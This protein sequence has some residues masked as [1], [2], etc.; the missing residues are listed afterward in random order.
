MTELMF[1]EYDVLTNTPE[2]SD[3][4]PCLLKREIELESFMRNQGL[5]RS[6]NNDTRA[7]QNKRSSDTSFGSALLR[8]NLKTVSDALD[9]KLSKIR[10]GEAG[11]RRSSLRLIKDMES[12]VIA[13]IAL[14]HVIN[15]FSKTGVSFTLNNI[16]KIVGKALEDEAMAVKF[17]TYAKK[18]YDMA[19][20]K[21]KDRFEAGRTVAK[22][23]RTLSKFMNKV[24]QGYF[25]M[26]PNADV[27]WESWSASDAANVGIQVVTI[28]A[29]SSGLIQINKRVTDTGKYMYHVSLTDGLIQ[30][31]K[32]YASKSGLMSPVCLPTVIPPKPYT[33]PFDG[34]YHSSLI[35]RYNLIKTN[36]RKY[37][38]SL[39]TEKVIAQMKPVYN[40][41]N[42]AASTAWRINTQVL[43]VMADLWRRNVN[44]D[45]LPMQEDIPLPVCPKCGRPIRQEDKRHECFDD[46]A[47]YRLWANEAKEVYARNQAEKSKALIV[48]RLLWIAEMYRNDKAIY[49][50]YQL[51]FRGRIYALPQFLNPQGSD[52]SKGLLTFAEGKP[53]GT[54]EAAD[55]LAIHVANTYGKDKLSFRDRIQWTKDNTEMI[56]SVASAPLDTL[57]L[58]TGTDSP[59]CFL[60]A[61][62]E[63][64]GYMNDGLSY[65]SH[66]PVAQ[67][68]TCSG[69]QHYSAMLRDRTGGE[70]VNLTPADKP[71]DIYG[72]VASQVK[73]HL[74]AITVSDFEE[75]EM[76]QQWLNSG[77][78]NRKLTK[79]AVMTLPYGVTFQSAK[80]YIVERMTEARD[81]EHM[82]L[83]WASHI[84]TIEEFNA[85]VEKEGMAAALKANNPL[86][87]AGSWIAKHVWTAISEVIESAPTAM[88]WLKTMARAV[89]DAGKPVVW[90]A[91]SG[92]IVQQKYTQQKER[93][94]KTS[95]AGNVIFRTGTDGRNL[96]TETAED[97]RVEFTILE[98]TDEIDK[99][100]QASGVA[101]NFVHSMDAS[102]LVFAVNMSRDKYGISSFALIHDSFGTHAADSANLAKATRDSFIDMYETHDVIAEFEAQVRSVVSADRELPE[103]PQRGELDLNAV[104]ESLYFFS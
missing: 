49:F 15:H 7:M 33:T 103:S 91:P 18:Q 88:A 84:T 75:Y 27:A 71:S 82:S 43:D 6:E 90:T 55:W 87:M 67:D 34:G 24:S 60:A 63:W 53:L 50:P 52:L 47:V 69:L 72:I 2:Y 61:C 93:T 68:G 36:D 74:E 14:K 23:Y 4:N 79:R 30:W 102:A 99:L 85:M 59:F 20:K 64:Q 45:C 94:V 44:V 8:K 101:P 98:D 5:I 95:L 42:T 25:G 40:A 26:S 54:Q 96:S 46:P 38:K 100:K 70:A 41:V 48:H 73:A 31:I 39:N 57:H 78:L 29:E 89:V 76:A 65:V 17:A 86:G 83:P 32:D 66:I 1:N 13:Y 62:F 104:R 92:L 21:I 35:R 56:L 97:V 22:D 81:K 28:V 12:E 37:L 77:L 80:N 16:G 10:A 51:D 9:V 3:I 11:H 58:W 19:L